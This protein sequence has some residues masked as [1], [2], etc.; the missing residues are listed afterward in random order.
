MLC[1]FI[2]IASHGYLYN[3]VYGLWLKLFLSALADS[4]L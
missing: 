1:L 2:F 4:Q 3:F